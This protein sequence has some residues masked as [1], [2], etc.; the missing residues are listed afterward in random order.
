MM[1]K[2]KLLCTK[3]LVPPLGSENAAFSNSGTVFPRPIQPSAPPSFADVSSEYFFA[4]SAKFPPAL[5]CFRTS[6]ALA[7]GASSAFGS[8]FPSAPG[9]GG[10][11]RFENVILF[12]DCVIE[13]YLGVLF[14][15]LLADFGVSNGSARGD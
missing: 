14:F 2:P 3:S 8:A 6:S 4:R 11:K 15:E 9:V 13:L 7:R 5:T 10:M 1:W 12:D